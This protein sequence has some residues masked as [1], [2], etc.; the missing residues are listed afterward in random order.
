MTTSGKINLGYQI[1]IDDDVEQTVYLPN[2]KHINIVFSFFCVST[3]FIEIMLKK[4]IY[5]TKFT[6]RCKRVKKTT[7]NQPKT[8]CVYAYNQFVDAHRTHA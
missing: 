5:Y 7:H 1:T 4:S 6:L 3:I 2:T 8:R